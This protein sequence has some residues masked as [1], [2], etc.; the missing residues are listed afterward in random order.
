MSGLQWLDGYTDVDDVFLLWVFFVIVVVDLV[1]D[2]VIRLV[3]AFGQPPPENPIPRLFELLSGNLKSGDSEFAAWYGHL[4]DF[5]FNMGILWD[6]DTC[7]GSELILICDFRVIVVNNEHF[8]LW[9]AQ[10]TSWPCPLHQPPK[11]ASKEFGVSLVGADV[12][13][14]SDMVLWHVSDF[15]LTLIILIH[16]D[17]PYVV[18]SYTMSIGGGNVEVFSHIAKCLTSFA[19]RFANLANV[20][21]SA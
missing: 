4:P 17:P 7:A 5:A 11:E 18:L 15:D 9:E 8:G 12:A 19:I 14:I 3:T 2:A 16:L 10:K 6:G 20:N 21:V 13:D 1:A